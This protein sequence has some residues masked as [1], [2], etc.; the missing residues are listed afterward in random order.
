MI[1][2]DFDPNKIKVN[3]TVS[4]LKGQTFNKH[5]INNFINLVNYIKKINKLEQDRDVKKV[6]NFRIIL[7][8]SLIKIIS[9]KKIK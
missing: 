3:N 9:I 1:N 4:S 8:K 7:F 2:I 6:N 5:I